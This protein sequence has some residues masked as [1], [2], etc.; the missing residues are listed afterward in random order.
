NLSPDASINDGLFDFI[1][2]KF[3]GTKD[4]YKLPALFMQVLQGEHLAHKD[5]LHLRDNYFKIECLDSTITN[6]HCDI[7]GERGPELPL[8]ISVL[9]KKI[10]MYSNRIAK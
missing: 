7:D 4:L 3:T 6:H 8:R 5:V 1:G 9:P 2:V 10:K